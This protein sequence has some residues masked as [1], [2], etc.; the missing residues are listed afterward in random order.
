[1]G[2]NQEK[3]YFCA[4]QGTN[5]NGLINVQEIA[6]KAHVK[7]QN[8]YGPSKMVLCDK[9]SQYG[10]TF[11]DWED[12]NIEYH[13]IDL[14]SRKTFSQVEIFKL[15][16]NYLYGLPPSKIIN[17]E[18]IDLMKE[19]IDQEKNFTPLKKYQSPNYIDLKYL[20]GHDMPGLNILIPKSAEECND[21]LKLIKK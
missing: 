6:K 16:A 7:H 11:S 18:S 2:T 5:I 10:Q 14:A 20:Y 17:P 4:L 3:V 1:M 8:L 19:F 15:L 13:Q 21:M 12:N 9:K